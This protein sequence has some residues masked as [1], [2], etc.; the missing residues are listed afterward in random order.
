MWEEFPDEWEKAKV[1]N[2]SSTLIES[3]SCA[4][5]A[6]FRMTHNDVC[7]RDTDTALQSLLVVPN[8]KTNKNMVRVARSGFSNGHWKFG[9]LCACILQFPILNTR[10]ILH[11]ENNF[12]SHFTV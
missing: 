1:R 9:G 5:V 10:Q 7:A 11:R 3:S 4:V 2:A 8:F 6:K 12:D